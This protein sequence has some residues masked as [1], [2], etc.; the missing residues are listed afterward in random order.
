MALPMAGKPPLGEVQGDQS[1]S[2]R[3]ELVMVVV[4][5]YVL[6]ALADALGPEGVKTARRFGVLE[7][8]PNFRDV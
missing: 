1:I 3:S 4:V 8:P 2:T 6:P 5:M 7:E